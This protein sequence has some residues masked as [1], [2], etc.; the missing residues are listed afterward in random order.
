M[1]KIINPTESEQEFTVY[2]PGGLSPESGALVLSVTDQ[3]TQTTTHKAPSANLVVPATLTIPPGTTNFVFKA[4]EVLELG[5]SSPELNN[6]Y[7][8]RVPLGIQVRIPCLDR[9]GQELSLESNSLTLQ[10]L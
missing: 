8:E 1:V 9:D 6:A 5:W 2:V 10:R 7:E 4:G 3:R